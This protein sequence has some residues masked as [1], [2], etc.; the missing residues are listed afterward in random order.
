[1]ASFTHTVI[2]DCN[3]PGWHKDFVYDAVGMAYIKDIHDSPTACS[4]MRF[5]SKMDQDYY[6]DW[7][8]GDYLGSG[9]SF[10]ATKKWGDRYIYNS[11]WYWW[12]GTDWVV[13]NDVCY[14][15]LDY[16]KTES[17]YLKTGTRIY[18]TDEDKEYRYNGSSWVEITATAGDARKRIQS[19]DCMTSITT[20]DERSSFY[21]REIDSADPINDAYTKFWAVVPVGGVFPDHID[22]QI[23][24]S[25]YR[26][27]Q[28]YQINIAPGWKMD[29]A[30]FTLQSQET[31]KPIADIIDVAMTIV[32]DEWAYYDVTNFAGGM[33][34]R[35]FVAHFYQGDPANPT[36]ER[37]WTDEHYGI[38]AR[39]TC[40]EWNPREMCLA[41][42]T[43]RYVD[44]AAGSDS[45]GGTSW[46]DAWAT[47]GKAATTVT[48]GTLVT[49]KAGTY[50]I[51]SAIVPAN[52][53]TSTA[54]IH[55]WADGEV[56][57]DAGGGYVRYLNAEYI[58]YIVW[59]GFEMKSSTAG[60]IRL[61]GCDHFTIYNNYIHDLSAAISY[62]IW[63]GKGT[64]S[65]Y[66][67]HL[68]IGNRFESISGSNYAYC[69]YNYQ[70]YWNV[71]AYNEFIN[72]GTN[73]NSIM[74]NAVYGY[75]YSYDSVNNIGNYYSDAVIDD[76]DNDCIGST[77]YITGGFTDP[78][79]IVMRG[80]AFHKA[81][82]LNWLR[83]HLDYS[84]VGMISYLDLPHLDQ[85]GLV[86]VPPTGSGNVPPNG[87]VESWCPDTK[88]RRLAYAK[89]ASGGV[90]S[91]G[92][93]GIRGC[94]Q[95]LD[96]SSMARIKTINYTPTYNDVARILDRN[97]NGDII[98]SG[99]GIVDLT[100]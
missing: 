65:N 26:Y 40:A 75:Y 70:S 7:L 82:A 79:P 9:S 10:P 16:F 48:A 6:Y 94:G 76:S 92:G 100:E 15:M 45:N 61:L 91:I 4:D 12:D 36:A 8:K 62:G 99:T 80:A 2:Q 73:C 32:D 5:L 78:H 88:T 28:R 66:G 47:I 42:S 54:P 13:F 43:L 87:F 85:L 72:N 63:M 84:C 37:W 56:I 27:T 41:Y 55:Y 20:A 18:R 44:G 49:V 29:V 69:I 74:L 14:L 57:I 11:G 34:Y 71:Y 25:Q 77:S 35:K 95:I 59:E 68:I 30:I 22:L 46:S 67:N 24:F 89:P 83:S 50:N 93:C 60:A 1:M 97:A 21:C 31:V 96:G 39:T 23:Y 19:K 58:S 38:P 3:N 52:S 90:G 86:N 53:G 33:Y 51:T 64:T 98:I 81:Y 17:S